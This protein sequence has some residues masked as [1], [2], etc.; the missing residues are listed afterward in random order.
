MHIWYRIL[1]FLNTEATEPQPYG[2]FHLCAFALV[3]LIA[4]LLCRLRP[5]GE[6]RFTRRLLTV[7]AILS[8]TAELYRQVHYGFSLENGKIIPDYRWYIF[9][10]QFCS[11]PMYAA[12][13]AA[14]APRGRLRNVMCAYLATYALFAGSAVML[15][16]VTIFTETVGINIGTVICHGSM[17]IL[18]TYLLYTG[19][20]PTDRIT[21]RKALPVFAGCIFIAVNLNAGARLA[22]I[23]ED[24]T[25][26]MFF[27]SPYCEP[28]LPVYTLVQENVPYPFCLLFYILGFT[29]AAGIVLFLFGSLFRRIRRHAVMLERSFL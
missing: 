4:V 24:H 13:I 15:Y 10:F 23:L 8:L 25:F 6:E 28:S 17:I 18:G 9:P 21:L 14:I 1:S 26:N 11:T 12:L 7:I 5:E 3:I 2:I 20:V 29:A 16:P 27:I 19:Y 22:G